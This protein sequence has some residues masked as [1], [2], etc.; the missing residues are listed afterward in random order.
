MVVEVELTLLELTLLAQTVVK[1][2][3]QVEQVQI[4]VHIFQEH[5]ILVFT[6]EAVEVVQ[7]LHPHQELLQ[8]EEQGEVEHLNQEVQHLQHQEQLILE[9]VEVELVVELQETQEQVALV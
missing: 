5:Q 9:V 7:V 3:E 1:Q 6:L 4:L 2:V 8:L